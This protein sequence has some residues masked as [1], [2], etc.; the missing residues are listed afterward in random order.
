MPYSARALSIWDIGPWRMPEKKNLQRERK[1]ASA[2][3]R[4][5]FEKNVR[6]LRGMR[7]DPRKAATNTPL[8]PQQ[9][10]ETVGRT[11]K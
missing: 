11:R 2:V 10:T 5:G 9:E 8:P 4:E 3:G 6:F 1:G 7:L